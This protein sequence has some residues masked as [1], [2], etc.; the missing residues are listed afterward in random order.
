M[1]CNKLGLNL[2]PG[3]GKVGNLTER[4]CQGREWKFRYTLP[5]T[6]VLDGTEW[7]R[8]IIGQ[9]PHESE[10]IPIVE[11]F[12]CAP[13]TLKPRHRR[14][15]SERFTEGFARQN[16][17]VR[18]WVEFQKKIARR[19]NC[20]PS[21]EVPHRDSGLGNGKQHSAILNAPEYISCMQFVVTKV[22]IITN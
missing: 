18:Q 13:C 14:R 10:S 22:E 20:Q 1:Y 16:T 15:Y 5:L 19:Q 6:S 17:D 11:E 8:P 3:K 2:L 9:F 12:W 7:P 21:V 4:N